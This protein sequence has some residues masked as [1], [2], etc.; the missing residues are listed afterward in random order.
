MN[1][2]MWKRRGGVLLVAVVA[3]CSLAHSAAPDWNDEAIEWRDYTEGRKLAHASGLPALV[4]FYADWCP[5][6]QAYHQIFED[7]SVVA[8][9]E[10]FVMIRVNADDA[11]VLNRLFSYDGLYLPRIFLLNAQGEVLHELYPPDK[12]FRYFIRANRAD[13]LASLMRAASRMEGDGMR[14]QRSA[15]RQRIDRGQLFVSTPVST[16]SWSTPSSMASITRGK[17]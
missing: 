6:C 14:E 17:R 5:T 11:P 15:Q 12:Q 4:V 7:P 2:I 13:E 8:A 16:P 10:A 1:R 3:I 9:S